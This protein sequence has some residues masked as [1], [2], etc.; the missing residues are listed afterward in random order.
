MYWAVGVLRHASHVVVSCRSQV[1]SRKCR[2]T[3]VRQYSA[4]FVSCAVRALIGTAVS[5][6]LLVSFFK[7]AIERGTWVGS[8]DGALLHENIEARTI[9]PLKRSRLNCSLSTLYRRPETHADKGLVANKVKT[10]VMCVIPYTRTLS[11]DN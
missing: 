6:T 10:I 9:A 1:A 2:R 8:A 7:H 11:I 5:K 3:Y 4:D